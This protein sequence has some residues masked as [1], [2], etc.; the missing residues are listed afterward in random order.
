MIYS[1]GKIVNIYKGDTPIKKVVKGMDLV[2]QKVISLPETLVFEGNSYGQSLPLKPSK[3]YRFEWDT[4][5]YNTK[6]ELGYSAGGSV[7][8]VSIRNNGTFNTPDDC[9]LVFTFNQF[10]LKIYEITSGGGSKP[11]NINAYSYLSEV[12][13]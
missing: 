1:N 8:N 5:Q 10:S 11:L 12:A 4:S 13:A 7:L 2:W 3:T 9:D 6:C